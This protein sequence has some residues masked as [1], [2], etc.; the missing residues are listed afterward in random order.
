MS[1]V[2]ARIAGE[3][4]ESVITELDDKSVVFYADADIDADGANGQNGK[5][6]AYRADGKGSE[7][8]ANGGM[9]IRN[10]KAVFTASWGP[11]IAV[12]DA[13]GN[14][15]VTADG[16]IVS[17]TAYRFPGASPKDP[18]A[19]V[20]SETI[21]YVVVPPCIISGVK[22]VVKGCQAF[23]TFKGKRV[24][25]MVGDVGPRNKNGEISIE[26]ARRLGIPESPRSGGTDNPAILYEILPGIPAEVDG[27]TYPLMAA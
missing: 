13:D 11:D 23:A 1:R 5:I 14:P 3:G 25:A 6:A 26:L 22:G 16:S 17:K 18:A 20:D 10:G 4:F 12:S 15:L 7:L 2:I 27:V 8:L 21:P 19:Y 9:G 24:A